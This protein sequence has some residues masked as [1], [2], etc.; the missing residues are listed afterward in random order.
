MIE[1][2]DLTK[3]FPG[4]VAVDNITFR[5]DRG[6]IVGFLG[7]NGAGK[8][9]TM[10]IL[11]CYLPPT[12]GTV[13]VD[14]LDVLKDSME[15]RRR[16]GYLPENNP[17][18]TE[19]RVEE[20]LLFRAQ[21]KRVRRGERPRCVGDAME[22]CGLL[23][24]RDRIIQQLSKGYRQRVG[25]ADAI[26]HDPE[27]I[28]LD[29][30]TI[31]LDPN[32]VRSVREVIRELGQK[33]TVLLSTHI[34]SEVERMCGRVLIIN[35]GQL[36]ANGTPAAIVNKFTVTGRARFEVRGAGEGVKESIERLPN[37]KTVVWMNKGDHQAYLIE[38][39]NQ[40]DLRPA[41]FRLAA[42]RGWEVLELGLERVSLEDA[43]V[44][45]THG[46]TEADTK[47]RRASS[48][49]AVKHAEPAKIPDSALGWGPQPQ[50]AA[51]LL[52]AWR[53]QASGGES[54]GCSSPEEAAASFARALTHQQY[55][56]AYE[57]VAPPAKD[58]SS[59]YSRAL[60]APGTFRNAVEFGRHWMTL[61]MS[62]ECAVRLESE[63]V[64]SIRK[65][66]AV[67][68]VC[69]TLQR[70][71]GSY[72]RTELGATLGVAAALGLTGLYR[73]WTLTL[74]IVA[75]AVV[76]GWTL[77]MFGYAAAS[78]WM[79]RTRQKLDKLLVEKNGRWYLASG[80]SS[81]G[82]DAQMARACESLPD[83]GGRMTAPA[84][85]P[86]ET[87]KER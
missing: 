29:E 54:G 61:G 20:Y 32:Q 67:A 86:Q 65:G 3:V 73:N 15:I 79:F 14:G 66:Y 35:A 47:T 22:K 18:Y 58:L 53:T 38:P 26:L 84:V 80:M 19:M 2:R 42:E 33:R 56:E 23:D 30:P 16:V 87:A 9:T 40:A 36:V 85:T 74:W 41:L 68:S 28:I 21:L 4:V 49:R 48:S 62:R 52:E 83:P 39:D 72:W 82:T 37:V 44:E 77:I 43:F 51:Q 11:T 1:V 50:T 69:L 81:D 31:G 57:L 6:E 70:T 45:A 25:L 5:V 13:S 34:L 59:P 63:G 17:L 7:P 60:G 8:S 12:T 71:Y 78:R 27:I 76:L 46:F 55:E 10:R 75:A 24:K 64:R